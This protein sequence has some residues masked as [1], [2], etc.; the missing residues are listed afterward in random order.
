MAE[1][2]Y[3]FD[4][5]D[6]KRTRPSFEHQ[7][8]PVPVTLWREGRPPV[9]H[10][11]QACVGCHAGCRARYADGVGNESSCFN[12]VFYWDARSLDIQRK[13]SDLLNQYGANAVEMCFGL[14]YVYLLHQ[15]GI[16]KYS[17]I[18]DCPWISANTAVW[19]LR[20]SSFV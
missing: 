10:R 12:S 1:E 14:L 4:L 17:K 7:G 20:N 18:P 19:N 15:Y 9:D 6:L 8:P 2:N 3:A 13:S 5:N 16:L 11:P